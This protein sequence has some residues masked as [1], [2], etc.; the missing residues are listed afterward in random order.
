M[1]SNII[2]CHIK[3]GSHIFFDQVDMLFM[4]ETCH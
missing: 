4:P 3:D 1:Y 2:V